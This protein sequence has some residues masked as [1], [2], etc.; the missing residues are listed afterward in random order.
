MTMQSVLA[1]CNEEPPRPTPLIPQNHPPVI[2]GL[3]A[4]PDTIGPSDSVVVVC[5]ATDPDGDSLVYDWQTDARLNIQGTP[6]WNKYLNHQ[7]SPRHTFYNANLP[8]PIN[9]SAWVYCETRD[10]K[11]GGAG[12]VLFVT[13]RGP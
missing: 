7:P 1:G 11:G 2:T 9:D 4:F 3:E 8:N 5:S 12:R 6:T 10:P 13:L